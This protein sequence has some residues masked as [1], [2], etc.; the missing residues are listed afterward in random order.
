[1][2][3]NKKSTK[4]KPNFG[5]PGAGIAKRESPG[6][7]RRDDKQDKKKKGK[8]PLSKAAGVK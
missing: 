2:K 1:M 7:E 4:D 3:D 5:K 8:N 6:E